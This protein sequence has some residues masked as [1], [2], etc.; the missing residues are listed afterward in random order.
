MERIKISK[1]QSKF[2]PK[3]EANDI[4]M[5]DGINNSTKI[6]KILR[7]EERDS[8]ISYIFESGFYL[9]CGYIDD[10]YELVSRLK[11]E[12]PEYFL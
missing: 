3:F 12:H 8:E 4:I 10:K 11:K 9:S 7:I 5:E 6:R 2:I 1:D